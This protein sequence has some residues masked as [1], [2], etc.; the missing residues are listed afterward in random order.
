M[1]VWWEDEGLA[2]RYI[3]D[4]QA[5]PK[6]VDSQ[7]V[8]TNLQRCK[9]HLDRIPI[10]S[11]LDGT[12]LVTNLEYLY[13]LKHRGANMKNVSFGTGSRYKAVPALEIGVEKKNISFYNNVDIRRGWE[14]MPKGQKFDNF[15][16]NPAYE[17]GTAIQLMDIAPDWV[18][19]GGHIAFITPSGF[20]TQSTHDAFRERF[21]NKA[22]FKSLKLLPVGSFKTYAGKDVLS[23]TVSFVAQRGYAGA[24]DYE[25]T[26]NGVV[27][28]T[29]VE[30]VNGT[31]TPMWHFYGEIGKNIWN[32]A[33]EYPSKMEVRWWNGYSTNTN[34]SCVHFSEKTSASYEEYQFNI[35]RPDLGRAV[36]TT[37][38]CSEGGNNP[39]T[40]RQ[41]A[42]K[43]GFI[44]S[45]DPIK[46][47]QWMGSHLYGFL[48]LMSSTAHDITK[49][50][51][52]MMPHIITKGDFSEEAA[53]E[54][55]GLLEEE[56]TFLRK[57][58]K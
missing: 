6:N 57:L 41:I 18:V 45:A 33:M 4:I 46:T 12:S 21:T 1:T 10:N 14:N 8:Y 50:S 54:E 11:L 58:I 48:L 3:K 23:T 17:N 28:H 56:K 32:K 49:R 55:L 20:M 22:G 43:R 26:A 35:S 44:L 2:E 36:H 16:G 52:G 34:V 53:Y 9:E 47:Y 30:G 31:R 13:D 42:S 38:V 7:R 29:S 51:V 39:P 5:H 25:R 15:V 24:Y 37:V 27:Y 40:E 19:D